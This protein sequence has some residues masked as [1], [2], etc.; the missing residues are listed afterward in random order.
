MEVKLDFEG[1][2]VS[3]C[4]H[5]TGIGLDIDHAVGLDMERTGS[6]RN[7]SLAVGEAIT[8]MLGVRDCSQRSQ[9]L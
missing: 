2:N 5:G 9:A 3:F 6:A 7:D 1:F 4:L 8:S